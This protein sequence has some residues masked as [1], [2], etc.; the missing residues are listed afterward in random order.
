MNVFIFISKIKFLNPQ[1]SYN[2]NSDD[3]V[4]TGTDLTQ[5]PFKFE[6][7]TG[8]KE[9]NVLIFNLHSEG[10]WAW[11]EFEPSQVE[12]KDNKERKRGQQNKWPV[13][14]LNP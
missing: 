14:D 3:R 12:E 2:K 11:S 5:T 1:P 7:K 4:G 10:Q 8:K 13:R 6:K 9:R